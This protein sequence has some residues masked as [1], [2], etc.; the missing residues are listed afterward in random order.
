MVISTDRAHVSVPIDILPLK[1]QLQQVHTIAS[2]LCKLAN[3]LGDDSPGGLYVKSLS[4]T[5]DINYQLLNNKFETILYYYTREHTYESSKVFHCLENRMK[6]V[7]DI[8]P[9]N[10][11]DTIKQPNLS[12]NSVYARKSLD[13]PDTKTEPEIVQPEESETNST[14][15]NE[16]NQNDPDLEETESE[17][18]ESETERPPIIVPPTTTTTT[19]P[20]PIL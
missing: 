3:R 9:N 19:G 17:V 6:T 1:S 18:D 7:D 10:V 14:E 20:T 8:I 5:A 4:H 11:F 2:K 15:E 13:S 16:S 12:F